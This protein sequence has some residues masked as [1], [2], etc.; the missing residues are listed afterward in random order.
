MCLLEVL[1]SAKS[2]SGFGFC[3]LLLTIGVDKIHCFKYSEVLSLLKYER[4]K[5]DFIKM[6]NVF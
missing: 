5:S 6:E 2:A 1:V 3:H 4:K